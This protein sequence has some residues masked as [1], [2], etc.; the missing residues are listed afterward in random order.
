MDFDKELTENKENFKTLE[1]K[2]ATLKNSKTKII[3]TNHK[4]EKEIEKAKDFEVLVF[5][6]R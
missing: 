3:W 2:K 5:K 4:L 1:N 6:R